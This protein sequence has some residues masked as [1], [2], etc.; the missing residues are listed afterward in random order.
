MLTPDE[1]ISNLEAIVV[2][3]TNDTSDLA[4]FDELDAVVTQ[5]FDDQDALSQRILALGNN[6]DIVKQTISQRQG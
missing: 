2:K 1:R 5:L 6:I 3:L 4:T